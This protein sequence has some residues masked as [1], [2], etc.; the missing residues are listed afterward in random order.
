MY[1]GK[2]FKRSDLTE[3]VE[4]LRNKYKEKGTLIFSENDYDTVPNLRRFENLYKALLGSN[5]G[6]FIHWCIEEFTNR[7]LDTGAAHLRS[8]IINALKNEELTEIKDLLLI[9][10][11]SFYDL[12]HSRNDIYWIKLPI[13]QVE[14][15]DDKWGALINTAKKNRPLSSYTTSIQE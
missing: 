12:N 14:F 3:V 15:P 7:G 8:N 5:S 1:E 6:T 9:Q 10:K 11:K 2:K 13:D 4:N